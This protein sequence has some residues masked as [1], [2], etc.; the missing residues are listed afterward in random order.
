MIEPGA[1][2]TDVR[3]RIARGFERFALDAAGRSPLYVEIARTVAA[4]DRV[5]TFLA[6]MPEPKWQP[7]VLLAVVRYLY[8]TPGSG[9]EF[10]AVVERRADE[11]AEVMA[12]RSTQTNE[13]AR[14]AMLLPVLARLPQPVALLEVGAAAGLCLLPDY[15]TY[16]YGEHVVGPSAHSGVKSP[17]FSCRAGPGTPL[18]AHNV[19]VAWRAGLDVHPVN[20]SDE[21]EVRWLEALVWPGEEYRLPRL[22]AAVE[23]ARAHPPR[24]V[25]GDL[26]T[27]LRA[28]ASE[29]PGDATLVVFHTAVLGYVLDARQREAFATAI[30]DGGAVWVANEA[31]QNIPGVSHLRGVHPDRAA[32]LLC[33]D[34]KPTAWTDGHGTWIDWLPD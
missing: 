13:P 28:L 11:I 7:N 16:G 22:R 24:V 10:V 32:F 2:P 8:G 21:A 19:E 15:Y 26:R 27:D 14:C 29:A 1:D 4:T 33:V 31:P 6:T 9:G 12:V 30:S 34:G 5:L 18:P 23:V 3:D 25:R 20:L 17:I